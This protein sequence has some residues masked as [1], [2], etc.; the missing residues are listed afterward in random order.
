MGL[1]S[2]LR[3]LVGREK[4]ACKPEETPA[5][6]ELPAVHS[7]FESRISTPSEAKGSPPELPR[8][9]IV[10]DAEDERPG[11]RTRLAHSMG[12]S[13]GPIGGPP[14][15][16]PDAY[17]VVDSVTITDIQGV[18]AVIKDYSVE[19]LQTGFALLVKE[20]AQHANLFQPKDK[21]A[22]DAV[23]APLVEEEKS[24]PAA[25]SLFGPHL[26]LVPTGVVRAA[27][28][29]RLSS[30][31]IEQD[32]GNDRIVT[33]PTAAVGHRLWAKFM[34]KSKETICGAE[35]PYEA[36][37]KGLLGQADLPKTIAAS[38]VAGCLTAS[39]VWIPLAAYA[40]LLVTKAGLKTYCEPDDP[41]P[42]QEPPAK[43]EKP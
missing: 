35:G 43:S 12:S 40:A 26:A 4:T 34:R 42:Q 15:P 18:L 22:F 3:Q 13:V 1:W 8:R 14:A 31:R 21:Q 11:W 32:L 36:F 6:K 28:Q 24:Q 17:V 29:G 5:K 30:K 10:S 20:A 39:A 37:C 23:L 27:A 38:I 7:P 41:A 9:H 19:K 2:F 33:A 25:A 16:P